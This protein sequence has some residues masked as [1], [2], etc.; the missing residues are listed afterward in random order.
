MGCS[1]PPV[2]A[3]PEAQHH[4]AAAILS[5][6]QVLPPGAGVVPWEPGQAVFPRQQVGRVID[7]ASYASV[8]VV[9][10]TLCQSLGSNVRH[11]RYR[12]CSPFDG[13]TMGIAQSRP[14]QQHV[15]LAAVSPHHLSARTSAGG[16][17]GG[18]RPVASITARG[19]PMGMAAAGQL[20]RGMSQSSSGA[21][22]RCGLQPPLCM[23]PEHARTHKRMA[24]TLARPLAYLP[25]VLAAL[26]TSGRH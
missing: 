13:V 21:G 7:M 5:A 2:P 24:H 15:V 22:G 11:S 16:V 1:R 17:T 8:T 18:V 23:V 3:C 14:A 4:L 6:A 10:S 25:Q 9:R 19:G 12:T 26:P 20:A